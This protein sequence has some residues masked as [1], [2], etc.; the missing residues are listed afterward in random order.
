MRVD[1]VEI[2]A[3]IELK[4]KFECDNRFWKIRA[5]HTSLGKT[6]SNAGGGVAGAGLPDVLGVDDK[7]LRI[8]KMMNLRGNPVSLFVNVLILSA[9]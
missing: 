9:C 1:S 5:P 8:L 7:K 6:C 4:H 3:L 2:G